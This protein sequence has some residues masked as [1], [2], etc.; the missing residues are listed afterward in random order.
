MAAGKEGFSGISATVDA[1]VLVTSAV[2][3]TRKSRRVGFGHGFRIAQGG[4]R[5]QAK[6]VGCDNGRRQGSLFWKYNAGRGYPE[7]L[8]KANRN[9]RELS[10][11]KNI[12]PHDLRRTGRTHVSSL[13]VREEVP[14]ATMN[15]CI[16]DLKQVYNLRILAGAE[17]SSTALARQ[18]RAPALRGSPRLDVRT[19]VSPK[20]TA[21]LVTHPL[22]ARPAQSRAC[23]CRCAYRK[24][25]VG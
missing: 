25:H 22:G 9:F 4:F 18:A 2:E 19:V 13:G 17:E 6:E 20:K 16:D 12:R 7:P 24:P 5:A 14:E 8:K 10:K 3:A 23:W 11:L 1:N 21:L 15:H